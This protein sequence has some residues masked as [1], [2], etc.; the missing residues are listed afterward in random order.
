MRTFEIDTMKKN[1]WPIKSSWDFISL[2]VSLRRVLSTHR[3]AM[4]EKK[5][6]PAAAIA[7]IHAALSLMIQGENFILYIYQ[8][9]DGLW[10]LLHFLLLLPFSQLEHILFCVLISIPAFV[11]LQQALLRWI[12]FFSIVVINFYVIVDQLI[13][14]VFFDHYRLSMSEGHAVSIWI[15]WD[16]VRGEID[17]IFYVNL[18]IYILLT[19]LLFSIFRTY[20]QV[21]QLR[22]QVG[23]F[24]TWSTRKA[25]V[26]VVYSLGNVVGWGYIENH[27][28]ERHPII[29]LV[30]S[31]YFDDR[32][33]IVSSQV[34]GDL[35]Q[36]R[37]GKVHEDST[38]SSELQN[39]FDRI[40]DRDTRPNV[41]FIIM[42]SVG[43]LQLLHDGKLSRRITP[44]LA[45][46]TNHMVI[47]DSIYNT[48]PGTVRT[49]A[50]INTGGRTIT[51]GSV[52]EEFSMTYEGPVLA[53][54]L[55]RNGY[56]TALLSAGDLSPENMGN[57]YAS[58]NYDYFFEPGMASEDFI[59]KNQIHSWG[60]NEDVIRKMAVEWIDTVKNDDKPF[61]LQFLTISTHHPYSVPS[62]YIGPYRGNDKKSRYYNSLHYNDRVIGRFID[63]LKKRGLLDQTLI[64]ICGD[65]GQAFGKRH[66]K[67]ITHKNFLYEENIRNF[68]ITI[69]VASINERVVSEQV[70]SV[71][72]IMPTILGLARTPVPADVPGQNL[73]DS[74]YRE[75]VVYFHKNAHPELW[76]LRDGN[77]KFISQ[78]IAN[79]TPELYDL[80]SDPEEQKNLAGSYSNQV[81]EYQTLCQQWYIQTNADYCQRLEN[82]AF[83][84]G[85]GLSENEVT[86]CGPKILAFGHKPDD[87]N[88]VELQRINPEENM[89]AW[90]KWVS[91]QEK[92]TILYVWTSPS[93]SE[94]SFTFTMQ[95]DWSTSWVY[96][97]AETTMEEGTWDLSLYDGNEKLI[98]RRFTVDKDAPLIS[99]R[100]FSTD[101]IVAGPKPVTFG[102][103]PENGDFIELQRIHPYE[104]DMVVCTNWVPYDGIRTILYE[105][106]SPSGRKKRFTFDVQAGWTTTWVY[107]APELPMEEGGWQLSLYAHNNRVVSGHFYVDKAATLMSPQVA[108]VAHETSSKVAA[109]P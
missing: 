64:V 26:V 57:L 63:D 9:A 101:K 27:N 14:R 105:W 72:D 62:N 45:S 6:L 3:E 79:E 55:K 22:V 21:F 47:F 5:L 58:Y 7:L 86:T 75:R 56:Q 99:R 104:K 40:R 96:H 73:F 61:F 23:N 103:K 54:E 46:M 39:A 31:S 8:R 97:G 77:W 2:R 107:H 53:N 68:C 108:E 95:P 16:S 87:G 89:V 88:F 13:Y 28:L 42:E 20:G 76:G 11:V 102:Y 41:V 59:R 83:A 106:I 100:L 49:H 81:K 30:H 37:F 4:I 12:Y 109:P 74:E 91:Y 84:G 34:T 25:A 92:K 69:D 43:S 44:N 71:G 50:P 82:H 38:N 94:R 90:T 33:P 51:W 98:S 66:R 80:D 35:Y 29:T 60:V 24:Q 85:R 52:Y 15:L 65:H 18:G 19:V 93:G 48:F 67:N 32:E 70:G 1:I 17:P 78:K 10:P 36:L